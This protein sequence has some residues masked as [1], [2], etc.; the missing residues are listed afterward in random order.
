M[1]TNHVGPA[2][3]RTRNDNRHAV[4]GRGVNLSTV[5]P[6]E[7]GARRSLH[8]TWAPAEA[9]PHIIPGRGSRHES[10]FPVEMIGLHA[11][12]FR[13][14]GDCGCMYDVDVLDWT[15]SA[16]TLNLVVGQKRNSL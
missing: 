7:M 16:G 12:G 6:F 1:S 14:K 3:A 5:M 13:S 8:L 11:R 9:G 4:A 15:P 10:R 2:S